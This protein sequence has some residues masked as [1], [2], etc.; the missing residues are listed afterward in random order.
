MTEKIFVTGAAGFVGSAIAAQ[1]AAGGRAVVR[2][3][4]ELRAGVDVAHGDLDGPIDWAPLLGGVDT[5][6]HCA[7]RAHVLRER[8]SDP[9]AAFRRSNTVATIAL[10]RAAANVGVRRLIFISSIGVNGGETMGRPFRADDPPAPHVPY[11]VSKLEA[12]QGLAAVAAETGLEVVVIR[13]PLVLG[14]G[15]KGNLG[16]L[17]KVMRR[18]LPLPLGLV[19]RNRR[20]LVSL[21]TLAS[22]VER[23]IDHPGAVGAPLLV[24]DGRTFSTRGIVEHLAGLEGLTPRF[25]PV[26]PA[27]LGAALGALGRNAIKS[28]LLGD[29]EVD[30]APTKSR[31]GWEP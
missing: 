30:I 22:L 7:A 23:C 31:L 4:R 12:E 9:L 1:L 10:A 5:V 27:L 17:V 18:G 26:P 3:G 19:T 20:D 21:E 28:Q 13:P 2:A 24:S 6:V 29:L 16:T 15:A 25:L 11:A 8:E 14:R